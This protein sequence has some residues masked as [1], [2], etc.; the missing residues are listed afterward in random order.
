MNKIR[1][2]LFL[3]FVMGFST[4]VLGFPFVNPLAQLLGLPLNLL[5]VVLVANLVYSLTALSIYRKQPTSLE[6]FRRLVQAN[7][8]WTIVSIAMLG[9]YATTA[10]PLGLV[11]LV[12]Q[13]VIV[14]GLSYVEG[15]ALEEAG[16]GR[17]KRT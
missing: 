11:F 3:D 4:A 9:L 14:G 17:V 13:V 5:S 15:R 2:L 10:K 6:L 1:K 16:Q 12:L 7:W 8:L